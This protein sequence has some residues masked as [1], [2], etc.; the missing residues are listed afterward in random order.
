MKRKQRKGRKGKVS[1]S[2]KA[3]AATSYSFLIPFDSIVP[4]V[5]R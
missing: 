5:R 3:A 1:S 2:K 4:V